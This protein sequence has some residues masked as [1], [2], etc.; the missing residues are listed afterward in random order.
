VE[1]TL[2]KQKGFRKR[3][4]L[5]KKSVKEG[6]SK[7][8]SEDLAEENHKRSQQKAIKGQRQGEQSRIV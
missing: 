4:D 1:Y 7:A 6:Q 5:M 3:A 2:I 8:C